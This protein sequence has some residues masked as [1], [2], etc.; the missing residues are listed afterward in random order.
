MC[1]RCFKT[2]QSS[3]QTAGLQPPAPRTTASSIPSLQI[4]QSTPPTTTQR[5][6]SSP[7]SIPSS[8]SAAMGA[9]A[10]GPSHALASNGTGSRLGT[11]VDPTSGTLRI[12]GRSPGITPDASPSA[13]PASADAA[14]SP[15]RR[16]LTRC[17]VCRKKVGLTGFECRCH[18]TFCGDHRYPDV[19]QCTFDY[20]AHDRAALAEANPAV[21]AS[22]IQK[23]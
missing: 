9:P 13:S 8:L 4:V 23:I 6:P 1:S 14:S 19:H 7:I 18:Q 22:K 15:L 20:K 11:S 2:A 12:P 10:G 3:K 17:A 5:L 16:A 21:V